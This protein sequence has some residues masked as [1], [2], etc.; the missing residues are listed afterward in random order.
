MAKNPNKNPKRTFYRKPTAAA[1]KAEEKKQNGRI[2]R[3]RAKQAKE[4][5]AAMAKKAA[6]MKKFKQGKPANRTT[7]PKKPTFF[8]GLF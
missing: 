8:G 3:L 2:L 5:K 6:A 7:K 1:T 4:M